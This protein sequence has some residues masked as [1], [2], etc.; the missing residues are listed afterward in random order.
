MRKLRIAIVVFGIML[1]YLAR[2]LRGLDWFRQYTDLGLPAFLFIQGFNA[3]AVGSIVG[4]SFWYRRTSSLLLPAVFGFGWL[5][6]A[7]GT[8]DLKSDAQAAIGLAIIPIY[9]LVPIAVLAA[10]GFV[11]DRR[12]VSGAGS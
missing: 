6:W 9:A 5:A 4:L 3:L 2:L 10:I 11:V 1:P 8:L 12:S 7:H